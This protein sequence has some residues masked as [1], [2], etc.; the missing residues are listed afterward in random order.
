MAN[1]ILPIAFAC[2]AFVCFI[3]L[4]VYLLLTGELPAG[5]G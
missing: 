2:G 1:Y 3:A 5:L 4:L